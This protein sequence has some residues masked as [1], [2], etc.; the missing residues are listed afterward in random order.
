VERHLAAGSQN[1]FLLDGSEDNKMIDQLVEG[2]EQLEADS[3]AFRDAAIRCLRAQMAE[4]SEY[5]RRQKFK[6]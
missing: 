6:I 1:T 4:D 3:R 2:C 5:S